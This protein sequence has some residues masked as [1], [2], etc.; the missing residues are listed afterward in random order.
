MGRIANLLGAVAA[1]AEEGAEG[2]DLPIGDRAVLLDDWAEDDIEDALGLV[3]DSLLLGE[4]V[5]SAGAVSERLL[6]TLSP[7]SKESAFSDAKRSGLTVAIGEIGHFARELER[8]E[9]ILDV[10]G[11]GASRDRSALELLRRRLIDLDI[12]NEMRGNGKD[13][14][15]RES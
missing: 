2:L 15:T 3:R 13:S 9:E 1:S 11:D 4:L 8:L 5:E 7:L 12:E 10:L 6:D 14:E